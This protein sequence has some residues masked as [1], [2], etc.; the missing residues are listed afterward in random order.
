MKWETMATSHSKFINIF[1]ELGEYREGGKLLYPLS[2]IIFL[3]LCAVLSGAESWNAIVTYGDNKLEFLRKFLPYKHGI[4]SKTTIMRVMSLLDKERFEGWLTH[5]A[6]SLVENLQGE[7]VAIDGKALRG[8]RK[9]SNKENSLYLLN[10]FATKHGMVIGQSTI[11]EKTNEIT[12]IPEL[13]DNLSIKDSVVSIDAIGC[14]RKIVEKILE[15]EANYFL[16]LKENQPTLY[17]DV[18][19]Y[20]EH[21]HETS[22]AYDTYEMIDKGHGRIEKRTCISCSDIDWLK[23]NHPNWKDLSSICMVTN[24][25]HVGNKVSIASRYYISN[26]NANAKEQL[27]YS[28]NHWAIENNLHWV[29][30][31]QFKEDCS[32]IRIENAAENMGSIRKTIINLVKKYRDNTG[33]KSSVATLRKAAGWSDEISEGILLGLVE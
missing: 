22:N 13:L 20:F 32:L 27:M 31:V 12:A 4:P 26:T 29:L 6:S 8:A 28:R 25:T 30:D 5:W 3:C 24:E 17:S 33:N 19:T 10:A 23:L 9:N 21:Y 1:K 15:K 16:A 7:Q 2:E 11:G 14:Q 18:M